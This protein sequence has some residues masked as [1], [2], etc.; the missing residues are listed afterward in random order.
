VI[1]CV[2]RFAVVGL[3]G[4]HWFG[5]GGR[6][7]RAR[8]FCAAMA[9]PAVRPAPEVSFVHCY[10][11]AWSS[12]ADV[13]AARGCGPQAS[14]RR[15][16]RCIA[17]L[18]VWHAIPSH[19][20]ACVSSRPNRTASYVCS[21]IAYITHFLQAAASN[22]AIAASTGCYTSTNDSAGDL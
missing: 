6:G 8:G 20:G 16:G 3:V 22:F 10:R 17:C 15:R 12:Y 5:G 4:V 13:E 7:A 11:L 19:R 1:L 21:S 9:F 18:E 14:S 2:V